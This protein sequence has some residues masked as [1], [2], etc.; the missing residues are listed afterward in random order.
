MDEELFY[1]ISLGDLGDIRKNRIFGINAY[2]RKLSKVRSDFKDLKF[3]EDV[4]GENQT[5]YHIGYINVYDIWEADGQFYLR[6]Y[7]HDSTD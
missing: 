3:L 4:C 1:H 2:T 6:H 7:T 5:R